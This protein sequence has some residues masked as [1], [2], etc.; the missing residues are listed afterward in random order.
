VRPAS[1]DNLS[2]PLRFGGYYATIA[3]ILNALCYNP[4]S[5]RCSITL[6]LT[7]AQ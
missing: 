6:V 5:D 2:R 3:V 1:G 4:R 7:L